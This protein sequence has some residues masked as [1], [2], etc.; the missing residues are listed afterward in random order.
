MPGQAHQV[1]VKKDLGGASCHRDDQCQG[2][3]IRTLPAG[4]CIPYLLPQVHCKITE[5]VRLTTIRHGSNSL[6]E[7]T[8]TP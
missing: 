8:S 3:G 1:L 4:L 2:C 6:P 5:W 7:E